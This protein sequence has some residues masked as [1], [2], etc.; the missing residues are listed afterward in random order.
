MSKAYTPA[1][2]SQ[3]AR[4]DGV[5]SASS[6]MAMTSRS[7][8]HRMRPYPVGLGSV[9]VTTVATADSSLCVAIRSASVSESNSGT[10]PEVITT[11]PL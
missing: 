2:T 8:V 9:V 1:L 10:S 11:M 5:A 3:M 7:W 4:W 6:T